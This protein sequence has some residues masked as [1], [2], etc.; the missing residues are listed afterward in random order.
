MY[1][2]WKREASISPGNRPEEGVRWVEGNLCNMEMM[3]NVLED[4]WYLG[5]S[6]S[7]GKQFAVSTGFNFSKEKPY[8][9]YAHR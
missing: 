3:M 2:A 9:R 5:K 4:P 7:P 6:E 1:Q 8:G